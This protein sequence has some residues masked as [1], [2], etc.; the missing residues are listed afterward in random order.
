MASDGR[1]IAAALE[2][3]SCCACGHGFHA[4]PLTSEDRDQLYDDSYDLG[5]HDVAADAS[6]A[7]DYAALITEFIDRHVP[8]YRLPGLSIVEYG[9]G[10]GALLNRLVQQW[11]AAPSLGIEAASGLVDAAR[12]RGWQ[13]VEIRQGFAEAAAASVPH[14][15][16]CLSVN[17][18]EHALD[19]VSFLAVGKTSI[20]Q[21]G[22]I[23]TIC[24]N[25]DWPSTELLFRDH[26]SSF[27]TSSFAAV[28]EQAG[29]RV[30]TSAALSGRQSGFSIYLLQHGASPKSTNAAAA[31]L[32]EK[33]LRYLEGWQELEGA[34][35]KGV[36]TRPFVIFGT[37]E[38]AD[39]LHAYCPRVTDRAQ[40][41]VV[42]RP[43]QSTRHGRDILDIVQF[44]EERILLLAAVHP[45][46]WPL[47]CDRFGPD[48]D[49]LIHPY[50]F[51]SLRSEL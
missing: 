2:K 41:Y 30:V 12:M 47:L 33:R 23:V 9:C 7:T 27:T 36:G 19:P 1:V 46:S 26:V 39:L 38:F 40:C 45:R 16:L 14:Y 24:P 4:R 13:N 5:L 22:L 6:R 43:V 18:V 34:V 21:D 31:E 42:D 28:A 50:Q 29:L 44:E 17:V 20:G 8:G 11:Q 37:G 32:A 48:S 51:S 35:L 10:S 49:R 3:A 15:D 25:G